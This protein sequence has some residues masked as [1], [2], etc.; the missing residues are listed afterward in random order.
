[1]TLKVIHRL[2]TF[3]H[4]IRRTFV[5]HFTRFQLRVCL[6]GSCGLAEL[7]V[8]SLVK[9]G[10]NISSVVARRA[11]PLIA[12]PLVNY[13]LW[14]L[15]YFAADIYSELV[16]M[17]A[18]VRQRH[19]S[20]LTH[21]HFIN[22]II[23]IT[24]RPRRCRS[25]VTY[26]RQTFPWTICRSVGSY[27]RTCVRR[28]VCPVHCGKTANR[29]RMPFHVDRTGSGIRQVVRFGDRSTRRATFGVNLWCTIATNG[30]FTA[31]VCDSA[32]TRP[33]SQITLGRLV[34]VFVSC[35]LCF[36]LLWRCFTSIVVMRSWGLRAMTV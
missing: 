2:Q 16:R 1:M 21:W 31:Y 32:A 35:T 18:T 6:H 15:S 24:I 13:R 19:W 33:S 17:I 12:E 8:N 23:I 3:S 9:N 22:Q 20:P 36:S 25:A 10:H 4:A 26:S 34:I 5:Q 27:V 7:L 11:V 29:I 14:R 30:D 28:S